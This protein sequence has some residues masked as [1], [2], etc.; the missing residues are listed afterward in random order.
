MWKQSE[1]ADA[2]F[3]DGNLL[4]RFLRDESGASAIEYALDRVRRFHRHCRIG[5]DGRHDGQKFVRVRRQRAEVM[6]S[7]GSFAKSAEQTIIRALVPAKAGTQERRRWI[8]AFAGMSGKSHSPAF[9]PVDISCVPSASAS[10]ACAE[11][12]LSGCCWLGC[13][14][15]PNNQTISN[16]ARRRPSASAKRSA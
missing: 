8:P 16:V 2:K 4:D 3:T 14:A 11:P 12:G 7:R 13:G 5:D 6:R 1:L 10:R 9:S 15:Q